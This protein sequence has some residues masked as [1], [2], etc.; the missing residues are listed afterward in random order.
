MARMNKCDKCGDEISGKVSEIKLDALRRDLCPKCM[1][2]VKKWL[3]TPQT[4]N[5]FGGFK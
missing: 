1:A 5:F 3:L 4:R 2:H